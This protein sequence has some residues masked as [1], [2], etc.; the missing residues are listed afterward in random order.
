[1]LSFKEIEISDDERAKA[2]V[3]CSNCGHSLLLGKQDKKLCSHCNH[4][5]FKDEETEKKYRIM[6]KINKLRRENRK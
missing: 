1:M 3:Y 2:K 5:V 6:E 4:Y